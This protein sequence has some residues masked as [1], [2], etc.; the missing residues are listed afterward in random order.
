MT[1]GMRVEFGFEQIT[2]DD[3][4][5]VTIG[6]FD[7]VHLGHLAIINYLLT[8]AKVRGGES[9]LVT[10]FPHPREVVQNR[11]MPILTSIEERASIL[12]KIGLDRFVVIPFTEEFSRLSAREFVES[13]L[14]EKVG[15]EEVVIGYDHRFGYDREGDAT[16]LMEMG[17][18]LGFEVDVIPAQ[19]VDSHV[20]SSSEIRRAIESGAVDRAATLL[21]R[22]YH[23]SG[24]VV[25][26]DGRGRMIGFPTA[27][28]AISDSHKL[29]PADGVYAVLTSIEDG[30]SHWA[31]MNI[32]VRPTVDGTSRKLEVHLIDF[33][34]DL[35][36]QRLRVEFVA[37]LRDEH[38]F[39][40]I[41]ELTKQLSEDR[42]RCITALESIS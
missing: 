23:L 27:N 12:E 3:A 37:R 25:Q 11:T 33:D 7:G 5:V 24:T 1:F 29:I 40:S 10:F 42:L 30:D 20:V 19:V 18:D 21:G 36:G 39:A 34:E 26:G 35:Y 2:R 15:V 8:R 9:T 41:E 16:L 31:M 17:K 14:V 13:V 38:K 6:T 22:Y 28:L 32:G 4:S